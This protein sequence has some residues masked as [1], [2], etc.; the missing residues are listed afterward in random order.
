MRS[1]QDLSA[2]K[3]AAL[4]WDKVLIQEKEIRMNLDKYKVR[5]YLLELPLTESTKDKVF[6][7]IEPIGRE[8]C[9]WRWFHIEYKKLLNNKYSS[10]EYVW[11]IDGNY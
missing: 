1:L 10:N 2:F 5:K 4:L 3:L 9:V 6:D 8:I 11:T 7:F